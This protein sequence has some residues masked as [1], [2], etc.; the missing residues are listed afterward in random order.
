MKGSAR[1]S[2]EYPRGRCFLAQDCKGTPW[3]QPSGQQAQDDSEAQSDSKAYETGS[4]NSDEDVVETSSY[5]DGQGALA[6]VVSASCLLGCGRCLGL[7]AFS[8]AII[9][10][11]E[12]GVEASV[13]PV[14]FHSDARSTIA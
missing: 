2:R 8:R 5:G 11:R 9:S 14:C 1:F 7:L 6:F 3:R 10:E 4:E 12:I 13:G